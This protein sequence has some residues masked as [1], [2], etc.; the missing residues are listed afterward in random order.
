M[1]SNLDASSQAFLTGIERV[2]DRLSDANRQVSSGKRISSASDDPYAVSN[3]LQLK[4]E[5]GQTGQVS[6]NL[7][8]AKSEAES[9]DSA[10]SSAIELMDSALGFGTEGGGALQTA[11]TRF[12]LAV[13]VE[14]L[15]EQMISFSRTQVQGRYIFSGDQDG[16]PAYELDLTQPAGVN[17]LSSAQ[18]TRRIQDAAG[19]SFRASL[20]A[21][22]IFDT[23]NA[24]GTPAGDNVFAALN[25]LR[26]ALLNNDDSAIT[27]ALTDI[28]QASA[29][30][31]SA[32]AFYG[33]VENRIQAATDYA[34]SR[35]TDLK[36]QIGNIEDA[37]LVSAVLEQSQSNT[38]LE[39]AYQMRANTRTKTLFNYLG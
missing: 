38:Q 23:R 9:A 8:V 7:V 34:A 36:T 25:N 37:D 17:Q 12:G 5:L 30:L 33:T 35:Q 21:Q 10:L 14:S 20:T 11:D 39:A 28:K 22:E 3:L 4:S 29:H 19:G 26:T 32:Q 16:S 24:D 2:Q 6:E 27:D 18:S 31:N 1:I 15:L 13:Q